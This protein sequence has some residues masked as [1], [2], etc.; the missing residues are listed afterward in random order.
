MLRQFQCLAPLSSL[1]LSFPL[2]LYHFQEI[3]VARHATAHADVVAERE[4]TKG[5]SD[6]HKYRV[7]RELADWLF[8]SDVG[9]AVGRVSTAPRGREDW[10]RHGLLACWCCCFLRH[11]CEGDISRPRAKGL[12]RVD[13]RKGQKA[14]GR[15]GASLSVF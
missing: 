4:A 12:E 10:G 8:E 15:Q 6:A 5:R 3:P 9:P 11:G 13:W 1:S 7:A 14:T 2:S